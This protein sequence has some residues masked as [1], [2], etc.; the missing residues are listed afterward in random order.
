MW[1]L[2]LASCRVVEPPQ[3]AP[4]A[5]APRVPVTLTSPELSAKPEAFAILDGLGLPLEMDA[6]AVR[7]E[8]GERDILRRFLPGAG[9]WRRSLLP[10]DDGAGG[11]VYARIVRAE[12]GGL[13]EDLDELRYRRTLSEEGVREELSVERVPVPVEKLAHVRRQ[14]GPLVPP[15]YTAML[16]P[17]SLP[18]RSG[19]QQLTL[20]EPAVVKVLFVGGPAPSEQ[21]LVDMSGRR[22]LVS[23]ERIFALPAHGLLAMTSSNEPGDTT[24]P[25]VVTELVGGEAT[26]VDEQGSR[27][28]PLAALSPVRVPGGGLLGDLPGDSW[29]WLSEDRPEGRRIYLEQPV[30]LRGVE[31]PAGLVLELSATG[32]ISAVQVEEATFLGDRRFAPG[33]R[34]LLE[35]GCAVRESP[36]AQPE[37]CLDVVDGR[38]VPR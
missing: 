17:G 34:L 19:E 5:S 28:F 24:L 31:L 23:R 22:F 29:L 27:K 15:A 18:S 12:E 38:L 6:S 37:R 7:W 9:R 11:K 30:R 3:G 10:V 32:A 36:L 13:E 2:L 33:T 20:R 1:L 14:R 4:V 8:V 21:A 16:A 35:E 26:V 25:V